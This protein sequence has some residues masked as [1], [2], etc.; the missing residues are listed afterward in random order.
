MSEDSQLS[1]GLNLQDFKKLYG[2]HYANL[3]YFGTRYIKD[4]EAIEDIVHDVFVKLWEKRKSI[5]ADKS[6]KSYLYQSVN[7]RCLNHIRDHK[8]FDK[9]FDQQN[10]IEDSI[11]ESL[12]IENEELGS[13]ILKA[14]ETLPD[15]CKEVFKLS[16]MEELKYK[17]IAERMGISIKTVEV[18][19]SKALKILRGALK[20]QLEL[21]ILFL[22]NMLS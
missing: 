2:A 16:R 15:R 22:L 6:V 4:M 1:M 7:N 12:Q 17:E 13:E 19:M 10:I 14:I 20:H 9:D 3:C 18:Q 11:D 5:D 21:L 8:K